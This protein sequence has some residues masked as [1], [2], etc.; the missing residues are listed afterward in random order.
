[1][2]LVVPFPYFESFQENLSKIAIIFS[3]RPEWILNVYP[4]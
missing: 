4:F 2:T 1:M 3:A